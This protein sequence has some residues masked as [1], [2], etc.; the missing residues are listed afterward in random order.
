MARQF[1]TDID[2]NKRQLIAAALD[3]QGIHPSSPV[4]G[5]FY[6]NTDDE[7]VYVRRGTTGDWLDLGQQI[8]VG[9]TVTNLTPDN[10]ATNGVSSA[11][12]AADHR[13]GLAAGAAVG[14]DATSTNAEGGAAEV[15]RSNHTHAIDTTGGTISTIEAG[16][17]SAAGTGTGLARRDHQHGVATGVASG[18]SAA[19]TNAEGAGTNLA[20]AAHTHAIDTTTGSITTIQ[21]DATVNNGTAAG[22]ARRDH[23]HAI[24]SDAP[25][26]TLGA[27][28][29]NTEGTSTSFA[30]ADHVHALA[31]DWL[32]NNGDTFTGNLVSNGTAKVTG[33]PAPT[34]DSDAATKAYVDAAVQGLSIKAAVTVATTAS[35]AL[36]GNPTIDGVAVVAGD[37]ILVKNQTT[38]SENG[39]Y[40]AGAAQGAWLRAP[41]MDSAAEVPGA[42]TFVEEG[43]TQAN[44][45]WVINEPDAGD[46]FTLGTGA[47]TWI[48]FSAAGTY[49]AGNGLTL[50]GTEFAVGAGA[51]IT[52]AADTVA[53]DA[54]WV[55]DTVGAMVAGGTETGISV[56]HDDA[57]DHF[58]FVVDF[59]T[60]PPPIIGDGSTGNTSV[61]ARSNH[62]HAGVKRSTTTKTGTEL[63]AGTTFFHGSAAGFI[64][65]EVYEIDGAVDRQVE[66][67][68][69]NNAETVTV[70]G[71]GAD[72]AKSYRLVV[73]SVGVTPA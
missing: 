36:S 27:A 35:I 56:T 26:G 9:G 55:R 2:L 16:D 66:V 15:A 49:T 38:Q 52:V 67:T 44:T 30:R 71:E 6:Y 58:D 64:N 23:R 12:A 45:G 8:T 29:V 46:A 32:R 19:T 51:G 3:N 69:S 62:T 41:D 21:P 5:Q 40:V 13:H 53:V 28:S 73:T 63:A 72:T 47:I 17:S 48:Q 43:T 61:A 50:T 60:S 11:A 7:T 25:T 42:F 70:T 34:S 68:V 37:R 54:E 1:L 14:L 59:A 33:L 39:I 24:V 20:R 57:G 22:L 18:L 10:A 31:D 4:A 65:C